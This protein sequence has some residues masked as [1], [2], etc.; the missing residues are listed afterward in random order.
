[1]TDA[2]K[3]EMNRYKTLAVKVEEKLRV[4]QLAKCTIKDVGVQADII[5]PSYKLRSSKYSSDSDASNY[6]TTSDTNNSD[7]HSKITIVEDMRVAEETIENNAQ[8]RTS[9][10]EHMQFK[11]SSTSD[12]TVDDTRCVDINSL[13]ARQI[14][15]KPA[16]E[17]K[18]SVPRTLDIVPIILKELEKKEK[19]PIFST[20]SKK[21]ESPPKLSRQGSYVLDTPS[22][23]L[24]AHM[25]TELADNSYVP[26]PTVNT[27]QRKQWD[28]TQ[29]KTEWEN[30]R[31]VAQDA[32][33]SDERTTPESD[34]P[35][36]SYRAN[37][38]TD[39]ANAVL[40]EEHARDITP[41]EHNHKPN[42]DPESTN[43]SNEEKSREDG[44]LHST[45]T[46]S[47]R[48][49]IP[50][51]LLHSSQDIFKRHE[52][53]V[54]DK[55]KERQEAIKEKSIASEKLLTVYKEIEEMHRK[56]MMELI[57][58][59][60]KEQSFLQ[61]E[62]QKQQMLLLVE[63][64]KCASELSYRADDA[65]VAL[66]KSTSSSEIEVGDTISEARQEL[67]IN[68]FVNL[69]E[70]IYSNSKLSNHADVVIC[71]LDYVSSKHMYLPKYHKSPSLMTDSCPA[72][73]GLDFT[74]KI[75][76]R[77]AA[78]NNNNSDNDDTNS[79]CEPHIRTVYRSSTVNRQ[80][81][82][83]DS[84]TTHVPATDT[85]V[86]LEKHVSKILARRDS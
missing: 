1:M 24:L 32:K 20:T 77:D 28:I 9:N 63:I 35:A 17:W 19:I 23:I 83:L 14:E 52:D 61:E 3:E 66:S 86:Y 84:N 54:G 51:E 43:L 53:D 81:F 40:V 10:I 76:L 7:S 85:S 47:D 69:Q 71:P 26:T 79:N 4:R 75:N 2:I 46:P 49:F 68:S 82:P 67:N 25:H 59:Q 8:S 31:L 18:P 13:A 33:A 11:A 41:T 34:I 29:R 80:L 62:F 27:P 42:T 37:E 30:E 45:S 21:G 44:T 15:N 36:E 22:P 70:K 38:S 39:S 48:G 6:N 58:R 73:L 78:S 65:D 50:K 56:Q 74:K 12:A 64:Q 55:E 5:K 57:D 60:R 72:A 16:E